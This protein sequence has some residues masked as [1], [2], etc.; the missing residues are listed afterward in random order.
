[1]VSGPVDYLGPWQVSLRTVCFL[2]EEVSPSAN[3]LTKRDH[4]GEHIQNVG[5]A[6][7][8]ITA[9][10]VYSDNPEDQAS[11][12]GKTAVS[13]INDLRKIVLII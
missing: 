13:G 6:F 2:V 12:D 9:Y 5:K 7:L 10:E 11:V 1:M 4:R 3:G 8:I